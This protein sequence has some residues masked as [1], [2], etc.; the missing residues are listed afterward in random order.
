MCCESLHVFVCLCHEDT[1]EDRAPV[2]LR[3]RMHWAI[4]AAFY[5]PARCLTFLSQQKECDC[6]EKEERKQEK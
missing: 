2:I 1:N 5:L 4:S 3:H 6:R